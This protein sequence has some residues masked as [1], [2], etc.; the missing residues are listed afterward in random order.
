MTQTIRIRNS[1]AFRYVIII[2]SILILSQLGYGLFVAFNNY[3][4][5]QSD[6]HQKAISQASFLSAV[7]PDNVLANNFYP[8]E[9]LIRQTDTDTDFVY[10]VITNID[11]RALTSFLNGN[12]PYVIDA[13]GN[14]AGSDILSRVAFIRNN[15]I[16]V[17]VQ[18]PIIAEGL[19]IGHV[20]LGYTTENLSERFRQSIGLLLASSVVFGILLAVGT[21]TLFR[22]QISNPLAELGRFASQLASGNFSQRAIVKSD[23]EIGQLQTTMNYMAKQLE[24]TLDELNMLSNV[25]SRTKNAVIICD[26]KGYIEW[27]NEAFI[28]ITGYTLDE[29]KGKTPGSILQGP[30]SDPEIV[31]FMRECIRSGKGF[32]TEIVNYSKSRQAYWIA[33][34]VQPVHDDKGTLTS[35]IAIETDITERKQ[36]EQKIHESESFKT[37]ILEAAI[38]AIVS[39]NGRGEV[40]EFNP[41]AET[42]FGYPKSDVIGKQMSELFIPDAYR[43]SHKSSFT[44]YLNTSV[45]HIL[46]QRLELSALHGNGHE[47]PIEIAI[48]EIKNSETPIFTAHIRDITER[49]QAEQQLEQYAEDMLQANWELSSQQTQLRS[50]LDIAT[51][52]QNVDEQ[53]QKVVEQGAENLHMQIGMITRIQESTFRIAECYAPNHLLETRSMCKLEDT[54]CH[55]TL[56]QNN[57]FSIT[58]L[59]DFGHQQAQA[60]EGI[61]IQSYIGIPL[62]VDGKTIGTL[63]FMS[64]ES[65]PEPFN[66]REHD[67]VSLM[68]QW[69]KVT[70]ERQQSRKELVDYA[71]ELK[72]SNRELQD[73]AYVA[74]HDLQ[75]PLRKIQAFGSRVESKYADVLDERG[76]DYVNRMQ[77]AANRMQILINDLLSF[78]RIATEAL[79]FKTVNLKQILDGVLSDLEIRLEQSHGQ[80]NVSELMTIDADALQMR[81]IFQNIISNALKFA[82]PDRTPIVDV[83]CNVTNIEGQNHCEIRIADNGVGFDQKYAD[84]IFSIFQRLQ[85]K[86]EYEGTGIGLAICRKIA[87]RHKGTIRAESQAGIGTTFIIQLPI[88]QEN[89]SNE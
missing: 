87:D 66:D 67:Y 7:S 3:S 22:F 29:V 36:A 15:Q 63:S 27:I 53:L 77:N 10:S 73:F 13:V 16:I 60:F 72:R 32:T 26:P 52:A 62:T 49:K 59:E 38:D 21:T 1:I 71:E 84:K 12:D 25:A 18:E 35:F 69:V 85:G 86:H 83:T 75:E 89:S 68:S 81:Q 41:A 79:P 4:T 30:E 56:E 44:R 54:L 37:G 6:L 9:T 42:T 48:T 14:A 40:I 23:D 19:L 43:D 46:G 65:R 76:V 5:Q 28:D 47:F 8:L 39:I 55:R 64:E 50:L 17:E 33:V 74:S 45:A 78:S 80:V 31:A 2:G 11:G 82:H 57:I 70:L 61:N 51:Q 34:E 20:R 24:E 58:N 88:E